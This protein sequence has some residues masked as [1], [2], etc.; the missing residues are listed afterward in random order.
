MLK[1]LKN[2]AIGSYLCLAAAIVALITG[3]CFLMTQ[4]VGVEFYSNV[5]EFSIAVSKHYYFVIKWWAFRAG[6]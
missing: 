1:S 3:I 5:S 4:E 6:Y 2:K